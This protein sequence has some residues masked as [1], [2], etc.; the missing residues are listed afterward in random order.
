MLKK[1]TLC[2]SSNYPVITASKKKNQDKKT[3]REKGGVRG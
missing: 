2:I 1:Q 3:E